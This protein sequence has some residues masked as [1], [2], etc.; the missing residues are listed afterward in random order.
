MGLSM[1]MYKIWI[2]SVD[3]QLKL[4]VP[5]E[6]EICKYVIASFK[7]L[8]H[9]EVGVRVLITAHICIS[10]LQPAPQAFRAVY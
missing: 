3:S 7:M 4:C 1:R 8:S 10:I 6:T 2:T 5:A 9:V